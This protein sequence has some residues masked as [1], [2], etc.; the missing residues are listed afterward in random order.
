VL[1]T[2]HAHADAPPAKPRVL[3]SMSDPG[4]VACSVDN[5][6]QQVDADESAFVPRTP[7]VPDGGVPDLGAVQ[8]SGWSEWHAWTPACVG[9]TYARWRFDASLPKGDTRTLT[10]RVRYLH[11]FVAWLNGV[12]VARRRLPAGA[13]VA[14]ELHGPESES[15]L[16]PVSLINRGSNVIAVE[17][18]PRAAD[19]PS[20]VEVELWASDRPRLTRG[21]YLI[22][23]GERA[24]TVVVDTDIATKLS[25]AWQSAEGRERE[26]SADG[27]HHV[28]RLDG[29]RAARR[30]HY[31]VT[32]GPD[33]V[34]EGTIPT[35]PPA[36]KPLRF[37]VYGDTRSGHDIHDAISRRLLAEDAD[38]ALTTGDHVEHGSDE[39]DWERFFA[40]AAPLLPSLPLYPSPGN[41]DTAR[42]GRG[43]QRFLEIFRPRQT[44]GWYSFDV[45][46]VHFVA[47]DSTQY[48]SSVQLGWLATDLE[49]ARK[50]GVRAIFAYAHEPP[51]SSGVHGDNAIAVRDYVPLLTRFG[52]T[53]FFGGHD[54]DYERGRVGNFDYVV[55]GGAGAELRT[56]RCGVPGRKPCPPRV[57][58]F[59]NEHHYVL[60]EL[61]GRLVRICPRRVDGS[62]IEACIEKKL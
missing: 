53:W 21:P 25:I 4:S 20:K 11:G 58:S 44:V 51:F 40:V 61:I 2:A 27:T 13:E 6:W 9:P 62:A 47:L 43:L 38:L 52:V 26:L 57:A 15:F 14:S 28:F 59:A 30:V 60:V 34:A 8:P 12:E 29:L 23:V 5:G 33:T 50:R 54:H 35:P 36:G 22:E 18:R 37:I 24:A 3:V 42:N 32:M 41:H 49:A 48:A 7:F 46:G 10:L 31:V 19:K 17:V 39:G 16:V 45:A 56:Q 55:T 1:L